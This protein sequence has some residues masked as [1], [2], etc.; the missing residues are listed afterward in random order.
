MRNTQ[1][2]DKHA[3]AVAGRSRIYWRNQG[4]FR[5]A[6][7]D[8]RDLGGGQVALIAPGERRATTDPEVAE[9]LLRHRLTELQ[10]RKQNQVRVMI[11]PDADLATYALHHMRIMVESGSYSSGWLAS[12]ELYLARAVE[13][14]IGQQ[15]K[16]A[17]VATRKQRSRLLA[18]IGVRDVSAY[19]NWLRSLP[20]GRGAT[21]S[22]Q[23]IR[24]HL[25]A[26]SRLFKR[27]ISEGTLPMG[28][29]PVAAVIDKP[30]VPPS[31][32]RL[33]DVDELTLLLES[34]RTLPRRGQ[35]ARQ[36]LECAYA[37]IATLVLTGMREGEA[38]RLRIQDLDFR[39]ASIDVRGT[40]TRNST[41]TVP[42]HPQLAEILWSHLK[43][44]GRSYGLVF[45][46]HDGGI[47]GRWA[48]TLDL[49]AA[50]VGYL[51]GEIR[52]RMFRVSYATY[53][54]TCDGVDVNSVRT[55][56]GHNSLA[57]L[58]RVYARARRSRVWMGAE[59]A[60]RTE[61]LGPE[62]QETLA[63]LRS[64][65]MPPVTGEALRLQLVETFLASVVAMNS[66]QVELRTGVPW[67]TVNR[68]RAGDG[69]ERSADRLRMREYL[70]E[71]ALASQLDSCA[72]KL[73]HDHAGGTL[74]VDVTA[75]PFGGPPGPE[76]LGWNP[77]CADNDARVG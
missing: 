2:E 52:T 60:F 42:M 32:T 67:A 10:E 44:L 56:L 72:S 4:A 54:L 1:R 33:L 76:R 34:A 7:A 9:D 70:N 39:A 64:G 31:T 40:K 15:D 35:G 68:L 38:R 23:A 21:L 16:S 58:E 18:T 37:L 26:L 19:I 65:W 48:G 14:F 69:S 57:M 51:P 25:S 12:T 36:P 8:L 22:R 11:D 13:F 73:V 49:V 29:N 62:H 41:R 50:R 53:R 28:Q 66:V 59:M 46:S 61:A 6:Y 24:H 5:R 55:E 77:Q 45:S 17:F 75:D 43:I 74:D 47:L 63:K 30:T 3:G 27:A 71:I 20:N